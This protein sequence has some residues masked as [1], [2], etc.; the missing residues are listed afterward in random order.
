VLAREWW[1]KA[2]LTLTD[3]QR[4]RLREEQIANIREFSRSNPPTWKTDG[5]VDESMTLAGFPDF[6]TLTRS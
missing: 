3:E 6:E 1:R 2:R 4:Q 5:S